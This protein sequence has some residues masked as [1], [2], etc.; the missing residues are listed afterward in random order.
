[1]SDV[2]T[3]TSKPAKLKVNDK[4]KI[5]ECLEF[6]SCV[7]VMEKKH[8]TW[9]YQSTWQTL[10]KTYKQLYVDFFCENPEHVGYRKFLALK[11][12]YERPVKNGILKCAA[13]KSI[14]MQDVPL[15]LC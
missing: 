10:N 11:P 12:F 13:A 9:F 2:S 15:I 8:K 7:T 6:V 4:P 3:N 14:Y 5:H 1:M